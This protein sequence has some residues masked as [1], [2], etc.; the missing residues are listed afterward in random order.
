MKKILWGAIAM[1]AVFVMYNWLFTNRR[2]SG[3][4]L[5]PGRFTISSVNYGMFT[6]FIPQTGIVSQDT[7]ANTTLVKVPIDELY[8][9]RMVAGLTATTTVNNKDYA[10]E[11]SHIYPVVTNGRFSVDMIFKDEEPSRLE[12]G[13][14][15]RMRIALG[16]SEEALLLSVGGFYKDTAGKWVYVVEGGGHRAVKRR[17]KLGRKNT[18]HFEVLAGLKANESV[19]TSTY[20]NFGDKESI[21]L[22]D[23]PM[24][25]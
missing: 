3:C 13:K 18:E 17:V 25:R 4:V 6:E 9:P 24:Y 2:I 11:I 22:D 20:E 15:L 21:D 12:D 7:V 8:L 5:E 23:Q 10:L 19:I 1:L 14:Q 16:G